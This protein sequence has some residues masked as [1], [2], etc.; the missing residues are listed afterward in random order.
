MKYKSAFFLF[1]II[2]FFSCKKETPPT[3]V[4]QPVPQPIA[5]QPGQTLAISQTIN[6]GWPYTIVNADTV[7]SAINYNADMFKAIPDGFENK[8]VSFYLPKGYMAVFAENSDGTGE[9]AC[10]VAA[11][12]AINANLPQRLVNNISFIRYIDID[13]STKKGIASVDSND[14]KLFNTS[15]YYGWSINRPSFG[16]QQFVPMT[17]TKGS[18][19][20]S[21]VIY[22]VGRKDV[23]HLLSFNE[24]EN[25]SQANIPNI[26]TAI[27]RYK[28]MMYTGLRL[29]AP[30]T[31]QGNIYGS[32]NWGTNF[33]AAVATK[34]LRVDFIP[35]HWYDWGSETKSAANDSLTGVAVFGRFKT[36]LETVHAQYPNQKLWLTEFN[37]NVNRTSVVVH[38]VFMRL[39]TD[40]MNNTSYIERYAYF[41][42]RN[43]PAADDLGKVTVLGTFWNNIVSPVSFPTN[44]Q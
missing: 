22:L 37:A 21:N 33:M 17:W 36:Y 29:G 27:N 15:W 39:S 6:M 14:V 11:Q 35:L 8:I 44:I 16:T 24:P 23:S 3:T 43:L 38:R 41:F 13:N 2:V 4:Q 25:T 1:L 7:Y 28:T 42:E 9:S 32:G 10:Y 26:D 31:Q 34:K 20:T 40:W 30:A 12:S 18:A 5:F 19:T